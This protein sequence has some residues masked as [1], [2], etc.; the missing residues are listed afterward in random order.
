[1]RSRLVLL[2]SI[3]GMV[4]ALQGTIATAHDMD[5]P[6]PNFSTGVPSMEY[7]SGGIE[8]VEWEFI[9]SFP[10]GN[11]HTD[12]DFFTQDGDMYAA[13]GTLAMGANGGGQT[14]VRL[15][16]GGEVAPS[17]VSAHPSATCLSNPAAAT[18][19]QHDVEATPKGDAPLN[20]E[21]PYADR[22]DAQ[23]L[24]DATDAAGR[25]H[26]QGVLGLSGAP[27]GG[28]EIIDITDI[29]NPVEI[30]LISNLG[31]SH[32][33][34]V[35]PKR[36]HIV[37]SVTS[38]G[39]GVDAN[40]TPNDFSDDQRVN[41]TDGSIEL[42]GFE[43][44]NISSCMD[45][46]EGL[47]VEEKRERCRPQVWRYR[48]PTID[49]V[50]GHTN[51][52]NVYACHELE[53]YPDDRLTCG[54]GQ[55]LLVL[56]MSG[57]FDDNGTPNDYSDDTLKGDPLPCQLRESSTEG[58]TATGA[59]VTDCVDGGEDGSVD[60]RV[61]SWLDL[62]SPGAVQGV[63]WI[64][65]AYHMGREAT[66]ETSPAYPSTEDIDFDHEAEF[67]QSGDFLI[68]TDERGGGV[69][70]PGASCSPGVDNTAGNGGIHAY[71][72]DRLLTEFPATFAEDG[73][74][75]AEA[76]AEKAFTS[77][78]RTPEGDKPIYRVPVRTKVQADLCTAHLFQQIPGQ[79]RIFM[80]WYS[81]GTQV[82]DYIEHPDGTFEWRDV[83]YFLPALTNQWVSHVFKYEENDDGTW[84]YWGATGDFN[85][86]D[87]GRS[88]I[89]IWKVTMPPPTQAAD[90]TIT[91]PAPADDSDG[92]SQPAPSD[93]D[94]GS[95]PAT[96][97]GAAAVAIIAI[98]AA[99]VLRR[100]SA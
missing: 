44:A 48:Y 12:I 78:A 90:G 89:D 64:G 46:P 88:A 3:L 10:T 86:G 22:R 9:E 28:L 38:D 73:T 16:E 61:G 84:T 67:T 98:G 72:T 51:H 24:I 33:T 4:I 23:L 21:N 35:D 32:T 14:V 41:E 57:A 17:Y 66:G 19:L 83:G 42:D 11:P 18:A 92:D 65:S 39:V 40:D 93:D 75:D 59:T 94:Q 58:P 71:R 8:G 69:A 43:I 50:R 26:D 31:E 68:A 62:G 77:Y 63:E 55:A 2:L 85:V 53:I 74:Y 45:L 13:V 99:A 76:T 37:Y 5:H 80:A 30:G 97:G 87:T 91:E 82:L 70:P 1:M 60:L 47:S 95:T 7:E 54:S 52:A 15:T 6:P 79:Q 96:G 49:M 20:V 27:A 25:C 100:R 29:E 56:D 36:P 81:Q 34:N